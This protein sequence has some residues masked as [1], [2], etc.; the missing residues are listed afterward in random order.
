MF[1]DICGIYKSNNKSTG[2]SQTDLSILEPKHTLA[3]DIS[4]IGVP[5][6]CNILVCVDLYTSYITAIRVPGRLTSMSIAKTLLNAIV[7]YAPNCK[8]IRMDNAAYF[9][10]AE[11]GNFL[12]S[13]NIKPWFVTRLNSKANSKIK[14]AFKS[15]IQQLGYLR[16]DI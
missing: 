9:K 14:R 13:L 5:A 11:F 2:I 1:C 16:T 3:I 12:T 8:V 7:R 4:Q 10:A 15:L 6:E